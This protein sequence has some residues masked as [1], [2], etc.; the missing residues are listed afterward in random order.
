[1]TTKQ[2]PAGPA[3]ADG[4]TLGFMRALWAV[5]HAM[6]RRSKRMAAHVGVT[7]PQRLVLRIVGL[8]PGLSAGELAAALHVHPSTLTGVLRRLEAGGLVER[9]AAAGDG[10]RAELRLT[11]AGAGLDRRRHGTVE[12]A[13]EAALA[14]VSA[15]DRRTTE[16]VLGQLA[17]A[18][19]G[20]D[21]RVPTATGP[22][23]R[24]VSSAGGDKVGRSR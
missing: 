9:R 4:A 12:A 24:S 6:E 15:R 7:G 18:L 1:M 14:P 5:A 8:R 16:R 23:G 11:T 10:R 17:A 20:A 3:E 22:A 2:L 21:G 13:V 19:D